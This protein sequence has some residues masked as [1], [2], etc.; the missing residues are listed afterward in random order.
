ML[1]TLDLDKLGA[2]PL[3]ARRR[4][5]GGPSGTVVHEAGHFL[6]VAK[7]GVPADL[8]LFDWS[9]KSFQHAVYV[10]E[11]FRHL[12]REDPAARLSMLANN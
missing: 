10:R 9:P 11:H 3:A 1:P 2:L 8:I 5:A 6:A 7:L 4:L 12:W